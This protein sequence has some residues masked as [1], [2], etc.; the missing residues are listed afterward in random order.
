MTTVVH[1]A[2]DGDDVHRDALTHRDFRPSPRGG[3]L[4]DAW[5]MTTHTYV[6]DLDIQ[7]VVCVQPTASVAQVARVLAE[8]GTETVVVDTDP[9][10][11]ITERGLVAGL[12]SGATG[13]TPLS[14]LRRA[15]PQFVHPG[16]TAEL[17][18]TIMVTTGRR[19][20][21]VVDGSRALGV[22]GLPCVAA[23]LW[24]GTSWMGALRIALNLEGS[25]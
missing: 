2:H 13:E 21:V 4:D 11:E 9:L 14:E 12:A 3:R 8:A 16:T 23:V 17:A 22:I 7:P 6:G 25:M 5:T 1:F 10:S 18:A 24:S 15:A 20:V 19:S